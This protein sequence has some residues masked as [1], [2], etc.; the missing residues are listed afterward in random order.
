[1]AVKDRSLDA[2]ITEAALAEFMEHDFMTSSLHKIADR[3]GVTT[4]ALYTRYKNK[5]ALF[6]S[7]ITDIF[8][9]FQDRSEPAAQ[10]YY[11]AQESRDVGDFLEAMEYEAQL[12]IDIFFEYYEESV[13]LFC[14]SGGSSVEKYLDQIIE[15]KVTSTVGFL[16]SMTARQVDANA[17]RLLME[18]NFH[19]HRKLLESIREKSEAQACMKTVWGFLAAGW[20]SLYEQLI[21][22][23]SE[24]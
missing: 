8:E 11:K 9:A 17:V 15:H 24:E 13:L 7:L 14:K 1:M 2:K 22:D 18:A 19:I 12:Y 3:A 6:S 23:G 21:E 20:R 10:K 5:D 4:G 16:Q